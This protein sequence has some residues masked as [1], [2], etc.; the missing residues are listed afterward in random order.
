MYIYIDRFQASCE[1]VIRTCVCACACVYMHVLHTATR[2]NTVQ[3]TATLCN[4]LQHTATQCNTM[5]HNATHCNAQVP[6]AR[7]DHAVAMA[8]FALQ[9]QRKM[10]FVRESLTQ[11]LGDEVMV[12][13]VCSCLYFVTSH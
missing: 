1:A 12:L 11:R 5:Q 3:P 7:A 10:D 6:D 13:K 8:K 9:M 4:A 2:N